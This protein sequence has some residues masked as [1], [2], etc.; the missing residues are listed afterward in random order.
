MKKFKLI[1]L[2][3]FSF[4]IV[5]ETYAQ[6][7]ATRADCAAMADP[8]LAMQ[9]DAVDARAAALKKLADAECD[10]FVA[11]LLIPDDTERAATVAALAIQNDDK[12]VAAIA[13]AAEKQRLYAEGKSEFAGINFGVGISLTFDL[14]Q[15]ARAKSASIVDGIVRIDD[16]DDKIARIMLESHYFFVPGGR[17]L[18]MNSLG[19]GKWG[20]G[21]FV[22]LQ[23][24]TNEIIEAIAV[25]FMVGFRREVEGASSW[26]IGVGYVTDPNV[27]VL[28]DGFVENQPPPGNETE[29]RFKEI[30]Q[31]GIVLLFSFTF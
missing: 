26:N 5:T 2:L 22:A 4:G 19:P 15:H 24:G 28:G 16:E 11:A 12:R 10:D 1:A 18:K 17:F 21:P 29:V 20:W 23:P 14:G 3:L 30:S 9:D 27:Q 8:V 6:G 25:G 13:E 31:D 7:A